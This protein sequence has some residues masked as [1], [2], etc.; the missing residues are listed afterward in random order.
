MKNI[1]LDLRNYFEQK[2]VRTHDEEMFLSEI[3][4]QLSYFPITFLHRDDLASRG[5]DAE[6]VDDCTMKEIA[7]KMGR[8]YQ[9]NG[10]GVDLDILAEDEVEKFKC[11]KCWGDATSYDTYDEKLSCSCGNKWSKVEDT[12]RYILVEYPESPFFEANEIGFECYNSEDNGARYIPEHI[13]IA[14]FDKK[15]KAKQIY[16]P[17]VWPQSQLCLE[18][19]HT[20]PAKFAKCEYINPADTVLDL[21]SNALF[22]PQSL[23][24]K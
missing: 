23:I 7:E 5:F 10:F 21:G 2:E 15:P 6:E 1:L 4:G 22:V 24:K 19:E 20:N 14:H 8:A 3:K 18:W 16:L 12:G 9:E 11:P 13:Y 17:I